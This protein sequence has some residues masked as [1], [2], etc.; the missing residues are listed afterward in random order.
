M[1]IAD[2][3]AFKT[4][5]PLGVRFIGEDG[6]IFVARGSRKTAGVMLKSLDASRP[7][8]L[9]LKK[10]TVKLHESD[11]QHEDWLKSMHSRK[12][13]ISPA[14]VVH[15]SNTTCILSWIAMKL[16]RPLR[17]DPEAERFVND[18]KANAM[19]TRAERGNYGALKYMAKYNAFMAKQ[20]SK[21]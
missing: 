6:W 14:D 17:W 15:R 9:D 5:L 7:E 18:D 2:S 4:S 13:P 12:P 1:R 21:A 20:E 8:L 3:K 11:G 16:G 10:I 19:L